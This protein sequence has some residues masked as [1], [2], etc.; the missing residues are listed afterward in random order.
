MVLFTF[1]LDDPRL[2][3]QW[4]SRVAARDVDL[5]VCKLHR[6]E[7]TLHFAHIYLLR[8]HGFCVGLLGEM[9]LCLGYI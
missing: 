3:R 7:Y 8:D 9:R 5:T 6:L 1:A 4:R 2:H